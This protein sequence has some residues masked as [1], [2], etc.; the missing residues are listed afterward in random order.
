MPCRPPTMSVFRFAPLFLIL[1]LYS[2]TTFSQVCDCDIRAVDRPQRFANA[3]QAVADAKENRAEVLEMHFPFGIPKAPSNATRESMI[4]QNEWVTWYDADLRLPLWVAYRFNKE[5][6][7]TFE[8]DRVD[9]FR[10]DNRHS[11]LIGA[12]CS[13]YKS[14]GYDRGHM[15]PANDS[16]RNQEMMDNS[17]LF[18]NMAPQLGNFNRI[19]WENLESRVNDWGETRGI[20]IITGSVFDQDDDKERDADEDAIRTKNV[21]VP[22]HFYKIV[23]HIRDDDTLDSISF[24]LPHN[25]KKHANKPAYL[26]S[27]IVSIDEIEQVTGIDF[28]PDLDD[29]RQENMERR[30]ATA[31]NRWVVT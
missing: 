29:E 3:E 14:S 9:C 17:F 23:L 11:N 30:K 22:T 27:R 5:D 2:T 15:V 8:V 12:A 16:K 6:A 18:S 7:N 19:I 10:H 25:N 4:L 13:D 26:K 20:Y 21:G 31:L 24:L 1:F 28:F